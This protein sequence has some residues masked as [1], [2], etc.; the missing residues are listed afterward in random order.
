[1][2]IL[3]GFS[4]TFAFTIAKIFQNG[5]DI[6]IPPKNPNLLRIITVGDSITEGAGSSD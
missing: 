2:K 3:I 6:V 4:T 5:N 1:M